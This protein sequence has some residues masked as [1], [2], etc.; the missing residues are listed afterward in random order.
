[1]SVDEFNKSQYSGRA[2]ATVTIEV[3]IKS[4][5]GGDCSVA[6]IHSQ[7]TEEVDG[8]ISRL[9]KDG[10]RMVGRPVIVAVMARR[11]MEP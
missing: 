1:M 4:H 2:T 10:I 3:P 7:A 6:Q 5:W 11:G 8:V 9:M